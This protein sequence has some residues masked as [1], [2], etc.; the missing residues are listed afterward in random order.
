MVTGMFVFRLRDDIDLDEYQEQQFRMYELVTGNPAYGFV[1][2]NNYTSA[3]GD[4]VLIAEFET[5]EGITAWR[6]N[7]EHLVIQERA[8][9]EWFEHYWGGEVTRLYEFDRQRGR[10]E[11][12]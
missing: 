12:A 3:S 10:V 6:N 8:R 1:S 2:I 5:L 4:T 9:T 7:P 11:L